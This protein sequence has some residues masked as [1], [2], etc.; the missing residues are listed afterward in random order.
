[1][2]WINLIKSVFD[3]CGLSYVWDTQNFVSN[4]W[5]YN[6]VKQKLTDQ[7]NQSW[8]SQ[9]QNS[10][11]A[12]NY[13]IFKEK[14]EFE[15]YLKVLDHKKAIGLCRFRTTNHNLPIESGRWRNINRN[16]RK[17][18]LCNSHEIGDEFHYLFVCSAFD[19]DRRNNLKFR[20]RSRPNILVMRDLMQTKNVSDLSKLYKLINAII[21]K[22][23][24]PG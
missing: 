23:N 2:T 20:F 15:H 13:R 22:L 9:V 17:C 7:F 11:K 6:T 10:P 12:L 24:S 14:F 1:M 19:I 16:D 3:N 21:K 18:F 5:L 8:N 4:T